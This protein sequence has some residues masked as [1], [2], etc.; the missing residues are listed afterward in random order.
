MVYSAYITSTNFAGS[1]PVSPFSSPKVCVDRNYTYRDYYLSNSVHPFHTK[2]LWCHFFWTP[3]HL[4]LFFQSSTMPSLASFL[5]VGLWKIWFD[6]QHRLSDSQADLIS[7]YYRVLRMN[8]QTN[9][10][11]CVKVHFLDPQSEFGYKIG[12]YVMGIIY[13]FLNIL[14]FSQDILKTKHTKHNIQKHT[15]QNIQKQN[16]QNMV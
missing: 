11:K 16:I 15:K 5:H 9:A 4:R 7:L 14:L 3:N 13:L 12:F 2:Q 1:H 10:C 8:T 6:L